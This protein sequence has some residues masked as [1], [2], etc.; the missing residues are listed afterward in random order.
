MRDKKESLVVY[1]SLPQ[2][3]TIIDILQ[4]LHVDVGKLPNHLKFCVLLLLFGS[5]LILFYNSNSLHIPINKEHAKLSLI[6]IF[7]SL[8][9]PPLFFLT[10][11]SS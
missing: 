5:A 2:F 6:I 8:V 4:T 10:T 9:S 7:P 1:G 11:T 3:V